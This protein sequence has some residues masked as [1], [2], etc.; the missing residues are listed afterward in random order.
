MRALAILALL[1][2]AGCNS[3]SARPPGP[4]HIAFSTFVA[5]LFAS[6]AVEPVEINDLT[7]VDTDIEDEGLFAPLIR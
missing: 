3:G 6:N 1:L 2:A 4:Q 7:F 5:G